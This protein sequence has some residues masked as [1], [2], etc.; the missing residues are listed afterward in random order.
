MIRWSFTISCCQFSRIN[1]V[2]GHIPAPQPNPMEGMSDEQK[3][4]LAVKLA[5]EL[6]KLSS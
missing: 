4:Y 5:T 3:E 1:P 6:K 2:T